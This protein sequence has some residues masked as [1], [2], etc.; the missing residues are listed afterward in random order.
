MF[1]NVFHRAKIVT[2]LLCNDMLDRCSQNPIAIE[3]GAVAAAATS[4]P[5][6]MAPTHT[7][8]SSMHV[9]Y[10]ITYMLSV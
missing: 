2:I 5:S 4:A 1:E 8:T 9:K 3:F 7:H 10:F 6:M